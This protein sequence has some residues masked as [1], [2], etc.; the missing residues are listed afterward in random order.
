M[1]TEVPFLHRAP[2]EICLDEPRIKDFDA[3]VFN[4]TLWP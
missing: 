4:V 1:V 3:S 2:V